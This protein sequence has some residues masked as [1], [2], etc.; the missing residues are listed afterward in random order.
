MANPERLILVDGSALIYRAYY[1]IPATFKTSVP[2]AGS[3]S[4]SIAPSRRP[5]RTAT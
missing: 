3:A 5:T 1:A 4:G 2:T